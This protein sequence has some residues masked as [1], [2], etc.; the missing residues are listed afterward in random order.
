MENGFRP[1]ALHNMIVAQI[2]LAFH[3]YR[4]REQSSKKNVPTSFP[5]YVMGNTFLDMHALTHMMSVSKMTPFTSNQE[6]IK[7]CQRAHVLFSDCSLKA[8]IL[9]L[10][11]IPH[12]HSHLPRG[13]HCISNFVFWQALASVI[14]SHNT[15]QNLYSNSCRLSK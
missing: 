14:Q 9:L 3:L 7:L 4:G 10:E 11:S 5:D 2:H 13:G 1:S 15:S 12:E 6:G 8:P